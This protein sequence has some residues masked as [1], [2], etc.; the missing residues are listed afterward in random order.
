M[1]AQQDGGTAAKTE[2][3][4]QRTYDVADFER[5]SAVGPHEVV[6]SV[7]PG[8]SVRG[9]GGA[10][11]LDRYEVV[12]DNGDLKIRPKHA[13]WWGLPWSNA[14]PATFYVTLPR[15]SAASFVGSGSMKIDRVEGR[16]FDA[17]VAGSGQMDIAALTVDEAELSLAG[18][19]DLSARGKV[20]TAHVSVAGSGD[21]R[22]SDLTS[23]TAE[24]SMVGSGDAALT[25]E[26]Q[27]DV[28]IVGSGDVAIGGTAHCKVSRLGSGDVECPA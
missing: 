14:R 11:A 2:Q 1:T 10:D 20:K 23:A 21:L 27:A 17:S 9:T 16:R 6:V 8:F 15:I 24:L 13:A 7:G 3:G 18:S 4:G 5:V 19:G 22:A 28:S 25:V 26:N 12:V